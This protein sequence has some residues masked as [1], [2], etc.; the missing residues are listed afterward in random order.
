MARLGHPV[1]DLIVDRLGPTAGQT[2]VDLGCGH[3]PALHAL[4]EREPS[5]QLLG[6]DASAEAI[7]F[8]NPPSW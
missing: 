4:Q 2:I 5:L 8:V 3:G 1:F 6:L 7:A